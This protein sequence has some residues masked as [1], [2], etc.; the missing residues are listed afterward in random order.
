MTISNADNCINI[1]ELIDT[2][3]INF[4]CP[5]CKIKKELTFPKTIIDQN[6]NLTTVSVP[7][8]I[9]CEHPFQAFI[10]KNYII[11]GY[12]K[13][14]FEFCGI[15]G[16]KEY[17]SEDIEDKINL[18]KDLFQNLITEENYVEYLPKKRHENIEL[19]DSNHQKRI[20]NERKIEFLKLQEIYEEFWDLI[21]D[22]NEDFQV[23]IINDKRR[24]TKSEK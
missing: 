2:V 4:I 16:Q 6:K 10:D 24:N 21:D 1:H 22:K 17:F 15:S 13:V 5:V 19:S 12:Q 3:N 20:E 23:L 11:R 14:D 7:R 8:N 18:D 9:I